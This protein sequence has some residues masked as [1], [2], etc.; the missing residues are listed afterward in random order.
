MEMTI[1]ERKRGFTIIELMVALAIAGVLLGLALPA[2]NGF[3][4]QRTMTTRVNEFV[5]A[6]NYARS[7]AAKLGGL[8]SI[9][10]VNAADG[11]NEWGPGYCVIIGNPGNCNAP[12]RTFSAMD[13]TTMDA[14]GAFDTLTTLSFNARGVLT[15]NGEGTMQLC[16][17][18]VGVDPGRIIGLNL[19]GRTTSTE[20]IC[21]P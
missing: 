2:F 3:I 14:T 17:T 11:A 18:D 19:I 13:D 12:L 7:E 16:S 21:N 10:A 1:K 5:L 20:L 15:V 9:Q 8:V 6:V 4:E